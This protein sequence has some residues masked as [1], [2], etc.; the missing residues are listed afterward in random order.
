M[1][2]LLTMVTVITIGYSQSFTVENVQAA[3]S[4]DGE[5]V[6]TV[7]YDLVSD[8]SYPSFMVHPEISI[9]GGDTWNYLIMAPVENVLGDNIFA[10]TGKTFSIDLDDY[11]T[12]MY[13]N[14]ALVKIQAIGREAV[15]LPSSFDNLFVTVEAGEYMGGNIS[16]HNMVVQPQ[17]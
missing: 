10:G 4:T 13:T 17:S 6:L 16:F 11:Y 2:Y 14:N 1:K 8:G 7:T 9:D 5:H 12:G 3:Q 15:N